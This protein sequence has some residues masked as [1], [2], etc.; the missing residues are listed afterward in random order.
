MKY[1]PSILTDNLQEC[2]LCKTTVQVEVHHVFHGANRS[3]ATKYG[4]VIGL[5]RKHH[6][7]GKQSVHRNNMLDEQL[8][9]MAQT[10]FEEIYGHDKFMEVF[11]KSYL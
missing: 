4:C 10:K 11:H 6:T 5:C 1:P 3:N 9:Q 8:K 2:Y 7:C